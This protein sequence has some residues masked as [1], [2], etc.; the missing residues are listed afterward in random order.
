MNR[1]HETVR[2]EVSWIDQ[3]IKWSEKNTSK[4]CHKKICMLIKRGYRIPC[5]ISE[6]G[7]NAVKTLKEAGLVVVIDSLCIISKR[8]NIERIIQSEV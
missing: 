7:H 2:G 3:L 5:P 8:M 6:M 1:I 4:I